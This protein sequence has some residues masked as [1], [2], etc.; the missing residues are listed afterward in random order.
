MRPLILA[1]GIST[2]VFGSMFLPQEAPAQS[3][4]DCTIQD[5]DATGEGLPDF[6]EV[7][8]GQG[9]DAF[10][11]AALGCDPAALLSG[12]DVVAEQP[13]PDTQASDPATTG[14]LGSTEKAQATAATASAEVAGAVL[15]DLQSLTRRVRMRF[16]SQPSGADLYVDGRQLAKTDMEASVKLQMVSSI[17][18]R[19]QGYLPCRSS[20]AEISADVFRC[21]F[22]P[23][24]PS[25]SP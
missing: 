1:F 19:L 25:A 17:E 10:I 12:Q 8:S 5:I 16:E 18:M 11:V 24:S 7:P 2:S 23:I 4:R 14:T 6:V 3:E 22:K 21:V 20:E 13:L 15:I 9:A